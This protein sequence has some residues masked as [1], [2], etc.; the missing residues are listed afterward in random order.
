[1][2]IT[3]IKYVEILIFSRQNF[4]LMPATAGRIELYWFPVDTNHMIHA[5]LWFSL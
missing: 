5:C 4:I 1:M 2:I 3:L